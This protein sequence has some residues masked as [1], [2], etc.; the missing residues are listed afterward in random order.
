MNPVSDT[1]VDYLKDLDIG[2]QRLNNAGDD[3]GESRRAL[4]ECLNTLYALHS[5]CEKFRGDAYRQ[6]VYRGPGEIVA[7]L[8][9]VR[10]QKVHDL[11]RSVGPGHSELTLPVTLPAR[12]GNVLRWSALAEVEQSFERHG[13]RARF[14]EN[15][16]RYGQ[17][18]GP[19]HAQLAVID[20]VVDARKVLARWAAP[21]TAQG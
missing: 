19:P 12:I 6:D 13:S 1:A 10:G 5:W 21:Q 3:V 18:V 17:L 15:L 9:F 11:T 20:S 4:M 16:R 7:A 14:E 2:V 8:V